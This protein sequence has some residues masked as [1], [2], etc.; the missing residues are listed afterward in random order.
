MQLIEIENDKVEGEGNLKKEE[1][2]RAMEGIKKTRKSAEEVP[3]EVDWCG[4]GF[5]HSK[6][7]SFCCET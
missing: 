3:K 1:D 6:F 5:T 2:D 7:L 4:S